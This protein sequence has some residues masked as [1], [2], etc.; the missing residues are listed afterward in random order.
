MNKRELI[1]SLLETGGQPDHAPAAFFMHFD[2]AFH[3]GEAAVQKHL[4]YFRYTG[5]DFVKIQYEHS[6]PRSEQIQRPADWANAPFY[7]LDF[8][9]E[10]LRVV[11]GLVQAAKA[12]AP[13]ILTLYSPFMFAGQLAGE[14][15]VVRHIHEDPEQVQRGMQVITESLL[16]F[17]RAAIRLG[18][19]GFYMS[20]QG[21]EH[22]RVEDP[23]LF[24]AC[25]RPYDL[26]LMEEINRQCPFNILH[27]CDY[28]LPY[29]SLERFLDYPGQVV[30]TSLD[31]AGS[32]TSAAEVARMFNRPFM[33]GLLRK[34]ALSSGTP[35]EVR[36][37]ALLAL[38]QAPERFILGADCT[39]LG[40]AS[41]ENPRAAVQAAHE[42]R[43]G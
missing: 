39:L 21:G 11:A 19:D 26:A 24:D 27:I 15:T 32:Q 30:N 4:E 36:Q 31:L 34:G 42:Y 9:Q 12:E 3:R 2:P 17:V 16:G 40:G 1:F 43:R 14:D 37:E 29:T 25:I 41:W 22:G 23:A 8:Y 13:V 7:D 18:L 5:M 6:Y 35:E 20:T 10:P 38:E 33:G 28:R